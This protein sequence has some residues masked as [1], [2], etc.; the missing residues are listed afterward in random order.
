M[1]NRMFKPLGGSLTQEVVCL[2]GSW[3]YGTDGAVVGLAANGFSVS[4]FSNGLQDVTLDDKYNELLGIQ[5]TYD[6]SGAIAAQGGF[7]DDLSMIGFVADDQVSTSKTFSLASIKPKDGTLQTSSTTLAN[8]YPRD[9][10]VFLVIWVKNS[11]V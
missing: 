9:T 3:T 1:A 8:D 6:I 4:D 7:S 10:K 11:S 5:A 2:T